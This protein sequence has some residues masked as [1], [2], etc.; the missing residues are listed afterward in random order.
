MLQLM[1]KAIS[2]MPNISYIELHHR[3]CFILSLTFLVLIKYIFSTTFSASNHTKLVFNLVHRDAILHRPFTNPNHSIFNTSLSR[4]DIRGPLLPDQNGATFLVNI[5]IGEPPIPQLLAMDTG[6]SLTWIQRPVCT[7]C[8]LA[9]GPIYHPKTSSTF[10]TLTCGSINQCQSYIDSTNC[11]PESQCTYS[12]RYLDESVSKG[13]VAF[14]KFTLVTSMD[15]EWEVPDLVFGFGLESNGLLDRLSGILGLQVLNEHSLVSRVGN[16]FS[17]CIGNISDPLYAYNRLM[18]GE[19]AVIEGYSTPLR[20]W[21]GHYVVS[22]E[23]ISVGKMELKIKTQ[24]DFDFQVVV[25]SGTTLTYLERSVFEQMRRE[26]ARLLDGRLLRVIV[27]DNED[28]LCYR[29]DL[30]RDLGGFPIVT[31]RLAEGAE[32][33]LGAESVFRRVADNIFCM[34][35]DVSVSEVNIIGVLAQQYYNVGFDLNAMRVSFMSIECELLDD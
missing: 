23:G 21:R 9:S 34:A 5:S 18:L 12:V 31:L 33:Y 15:G 13:I 32:V 16:K 2:T 22:L 25:D 27:N 14:E 19:G 6:S 8:T 24:R 4:D 20:I 30:G 35:V 26:V 28:R 1:A 17:Y 3:H 11:G 29:G 7:G 10:K